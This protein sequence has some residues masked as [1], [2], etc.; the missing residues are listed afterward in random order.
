MS[1]HQSQLLKYSHVVN[2]ANMTTNEAFMSNSAMQGIFPAEKTVCAKYLGTLGGQWPTPQRG[3]WFPN[4][5]DIDSYRDN[6]RALCPV[7]DEKLKLIKKTK[8]YKLL[9]YQRDYSRKISNEPGLFR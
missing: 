2:I 1:V 7:T 4:P 5:G 6:I 3:H 9:I 8:K